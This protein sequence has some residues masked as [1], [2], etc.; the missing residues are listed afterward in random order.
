MKYT[1]F[2]IAM[3]SLAKVSFF[4]EFFYWKWTDLPCFNYHRSKSIQMHERKKEWK[5]VSWSVFLPLYLPD[6]R[7]L[8]VVANAIFTQEVKLHH[9]LTAVQ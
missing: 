2:E 6:D 9:T 7:D 4:A 1:D 8:V 5:C 3:N